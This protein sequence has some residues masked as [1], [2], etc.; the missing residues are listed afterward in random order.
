[1]SKEITDNLS[2]NLSAKL[3]IAN[4]AKIDYETL[5]MATQQFESASPIKKT[6]GVGEFGMGFTYKLPI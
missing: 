5:N 2:V 4:N 6:I 3:Q 1:M